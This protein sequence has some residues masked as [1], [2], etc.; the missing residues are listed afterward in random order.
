V[1]VDVRDTL[2]GAYVLM[3]DD[4]VD[5]TTN[6]TG[7]VTEMTLAEI[8]ALEVTDW[9]YLNHYPGLRVPTFA[10]ALE[11]VDA[12]AGQVDIDMK[13]DEVEGAIQVVVDLGLEERCF[14]YSSDP[15]KLD[16]VRA[17]STAV[18]IQPSTPSVEHTQYLLDH[19]DPDP[20]HIELAD[21]GFTAENITL[22]KSAGA[23][24]FM[25]ALGTRDYL[26]V[27][28]FKP[29]WRAMMEAGV[30][31]MQTDFPGELIEY[32]DSLCE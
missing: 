14:V 22:I 29:A 16:R 21:G 31:I 28:G 17:I 7:T 23:V 15:T 2:D 20:E 19:F 30:E 27:L 11:A 25:D 1:E 9:M 32:R 26:A 3:H 12:A 18:R 6:G 8:K 10:E 4:T 5:R 24:V 13:T